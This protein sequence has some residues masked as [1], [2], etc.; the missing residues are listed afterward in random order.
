MANQ[1]TGPRKLR[2]G[3]QGREP[4]R[5]DRQVDAERQPLL[6]HIMALRRVLVVSLAAVAVG[7]L[8]AFYFF[9]TPLM[10]FLTQPIEARG[11]QII[12]TAVSE[13]LS[14]QL[15]VALMAGA[16][17]ASP[18]VFYELWSFFKPALYDHE[19][20]AFRLIFFSALVLFLLGIVFCYNVVYGLTLDFFLIAGENL[21]TPML[22]ID[23]YVGF[24]FSFLLPIGVAFEL[25]VALYFTTRM[26]WTTYAKLARSRRYVLLA[27]V[28][29]A[30]ILTPPDV[31]SQIMLSVPMYALFEIGLQVSRFVKPRRG[32]QADGSPEEA[33]VEN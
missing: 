10:D 26:G 8:V 16:V 21:A 23:K 7:F 33:Q 6:Y 1:E 32:P 9:I 15:K 31:V 24:L 19:I 28:I 22:S 13:A 17:L 18:V 20:A 30:A 29:V 27:I 11:V 4:S 3:K 25:P 12:Y 14:T 2:L 5:H